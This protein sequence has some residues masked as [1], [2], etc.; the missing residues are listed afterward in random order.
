M[1]LI[2]RSACANAS[3]GNRMAV[4][5]LLWQE[6]EQ[7][8]CGGIGALENWG[9]PGVDDSACGAC[10]SML[11]KL[12]G[13][14]DPALSTSS[15]VQRAYANTDCVLRWISIWRRGAA[16]CDPNDCAVNDGD[17][18]GKPDDCPE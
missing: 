18:S 1:D 10:V 2:D 3:C 7:S 13:F 5:G 9:V 15:K 17:L 11:C 4:H 14:I 16:V 6:V 8:F 12:M